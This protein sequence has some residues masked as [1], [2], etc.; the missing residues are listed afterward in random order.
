LGGNG[1]GVTPHGWH[2]IRITEV[3]YKKRGVK[4]DHF[5]GG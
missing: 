3:S 2:G 4:K 1:R 5:M